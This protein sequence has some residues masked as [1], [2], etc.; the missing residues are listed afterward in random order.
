MSFTI[1][2]D[3]A[4]VGAGPAGLS[5]ALAAANAGAR[6]VV[7]DEYAEPGGQFYKQLPAEFS[8]PDRAQLDDDYT[9]GD[10]LLAAVKKA[11]VTISNETLV[12]GAFETGVLSVRRRGEAGSVKARTIVVASGAY[13]RAIA[14]PG[15]DLPG[16]MT[17]GGAQTLA[18]NQ[19]Q[20]PGKRIVLAG[21]GPFLL[22]VTKTLLGAGAHIAA[23]YEATR[24][25]E[26]VRH[27]PRLWGHWDRIAEALRYRRMLADAG[28]SIRFGRIVV[29]AEGAEA[30]E[31]VVTMECDA[32]GQTIAGSEQ[33]EACDTLCV[34]YGF[35]PQVQLTRLLG[36]EHRYDAL[37]GGWVPKFG[38][39]MQ[40]SVPGVYVAG[41]IAGIGGAYTALAEGWVAG[42][43]AA[44]A[45][46]HKIREMSLL[47]AQ[48][49]RTT[50]RKFGDIVNVVFAVKPGIFELIADDTLVC[51]CEEVTAGEI[52][53]A[54]AA[55]G[56]SAGAVKGV[57]RCGMGY[58]QGRIC[59]SLLEELTA[60]A[61]GCAREEVGGLS[62]RPPLKP[63][64]VGELADLAE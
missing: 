26:W 3:L 7:L 46:G 25:R 13:E 5:A 31:R 15:W 54:V 41:E 28:L 19:Q 1:D 14:F 22:P 59:G 37:R 18:K 30:V 35:I 58:C 33:V 50:R 24:P 40:T 8:V 44:R 60:R 38:S 17:P 36:C 2:A 6:V 16:V 57:T 42:L 49:E 9:K 4:V 48:R 39:D 64:R 45:L 51:R 53:A 23:I 47:S 12:W 56:A 32:G 61:A 55:W 10:A 62:V 27:A 34:G 43:G 11:G 29:R 21:S 52:R 20:L 63:V